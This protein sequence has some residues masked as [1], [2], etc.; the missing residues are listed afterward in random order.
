MIWL[1]STVSEPAQ[2]LWFG[3]R[4]GHTVLNHNAQMQMGRRR[5]KKWDFSLWFDEIVTIWT[6]GRWFSLWF[7]TRPAAGGKKIGILACDLMILLRFPAFF[8]RFSLWFG[9]L[10]RPESQFFAQI[11]RIAQNR[12]QII[13]SGYHPPPPPPPGGCSVEERVSWWSALPYFASP[14]A[15]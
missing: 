8:N 2:C 7:D 12:P 6:V 1:T 10:R 3:H 13:R 5:L 11:I 15:A 14:A 9:R 4:Y